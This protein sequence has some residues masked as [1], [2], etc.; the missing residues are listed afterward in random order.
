MIL[1]KRKSQFAHSSRNDDSGAWW[2][3]NNE[4][5]RD[6][7]GRKSLGYCENLDGLQQMVKGLRSNKYLNAAG[8]RAL[9]F[10]VISAAEFGRAFSHGNLLIYMGL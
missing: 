9:K 2:G 4:R 5:I 7:I 8:T 1:L 3:S 10:N 6:K